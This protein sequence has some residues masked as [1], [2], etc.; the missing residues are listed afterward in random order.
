MKL[1]GKPPQFIHQLYDMRVMDG[2]EAKLTCK[3]TGWPAPEVEW[4]KS[5]Q[6]VTDTPDFKLHYARESGDCIL[7][8]LEVFPQDS[9]EYRCVAVN[10]YGKDVTSCT[11]TVEG[12]F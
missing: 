11:L 9:A 8:I 3:V 1:E 5:G 6:K 4:Y 12:I 10:P 2:E 7:H